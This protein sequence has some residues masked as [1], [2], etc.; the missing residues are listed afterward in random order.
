MGAFEA[1]RT[2][3]WEIPMGNPY[4]VVYRRV[5]PLNVSLGILG[6]F[7]SYGWVNFC[8]DRPT[9]RMGSQDGRKW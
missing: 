5:S 3:S 9:W 2:P 7:W 8:G 6:F 1:Q 4:I